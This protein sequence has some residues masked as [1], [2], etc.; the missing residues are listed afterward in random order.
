MLMGFSGLV[1][2]FSS[3]SSALV[4]L[5]FSVAGGCCAPCCVVPLWSLRRS[6]PLVL[7]GREREVAVVLV[8]STS[9]SNFV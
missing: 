1:F 5:R 8:V 9:T 3:L 7:F 4:S 6:A 2:G